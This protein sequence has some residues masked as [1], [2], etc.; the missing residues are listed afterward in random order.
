MKQVEVPL[1]EPPEIVNLG[2][3][4]HG[5]HSL[6]H[7]YL[8]PELWQLHLYDY[9]AQLTLNG[10]GGGAVHTIEP[11]SVSLIPP[12]TKAAYRYRGPSEHLYVHFR[13]PEA[14]GREVPVI[15]GTGVQAPALSDMLRTAIAAAP[16]TP[17]SA[18]AE[19][20]A[21]LWRVAEL[22][23]NEGNTHSAV[24][25]A[26]SYI[27]ARLSSALSVSEIARHAGIS[28]NHLTRLFKAETGLTVVAYI[29]RRRMI[30]ARHLL[31]ESS[32]PISAIATSVGIPDLQAFNKV[33]RRVLGAAPRA[34]RATS[35]TANPVSMAT[36]G[37]LAEDE[38]REAE[39]AN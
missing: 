22:G 9:T 21:A 23:G 27:E 24:A 26:I 33:C 1:E 28:H 25:T 7:T 8:L 2:V 11:G 4:R 6:R 20:W 19:V 32:M 5:V 18:A 37:D 17:A 16:K 29:R 31:V 38:G 12:G 39:R 14:R 34:I 13:L 36:R 10:I 30:R 35:A 3:G 15:Q